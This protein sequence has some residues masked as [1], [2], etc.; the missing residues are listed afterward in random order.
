MQ[1]RAFGYVCVPAERL[2]EQVR[3]VRE[4]LAR[5]QLEEAR[6]M[7]SCA[8]APALGYF[9]WRE[10][11]KHS[12]EARDFLFA[13]E[14]AGEAEW[15]DEEKQREPFYIPHFVELG[16]EL[17]SIGRCEL[18]LEIADG[19]LSSLRE[20]Q[21]GYRQRRLRCRMLLELVKTLAAMGEVHEALRLARRLQPG[22]GLEFAC[23][24][25][26]AVARAE[27]AGKQ[28]ETIAAEI[29]RILKEKEREIPAAL[30]AKV[31]L[32][33]GK[34]TGDA[35]YL[36][37]ALGKA[38]EARSSGEQGGLFFRIACAALGVEDG[39]GEW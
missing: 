33:L 12:E 30:A 1:E 21:Q 17:E 14:A 34:L 37:C 6:Q 13:F 10:I 8:S 31:Y 5:G 32:E 20:E 23:R 2:E 29:L 22:A 35:K 24:G 28:T 7:A 4:C 36:R 27:K 15:W 19:I 25:L 18:V 11:V 39:H 9:L 26:L 3:K 38:A 16:L